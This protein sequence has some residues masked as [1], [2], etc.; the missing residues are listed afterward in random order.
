MFDN[1]KSSNVLDEVHPEDC[2]LWEVTKSARCMV[3]LK[4]IYGVLDAIPYTAITASALI[5]KLP[6]SPKVLTRLVAETW[7]LTHPGFLCLQHWGS[8]L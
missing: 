7:H 1:L 5:R 3:P 2:A 8:N 6:A 4:N